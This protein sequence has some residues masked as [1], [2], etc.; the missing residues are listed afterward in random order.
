[1]YLI[2][3]FLGVLYIIDIINRNLYKILPSIK[4]S[5]FF[6]R[7]LDIKEVLSLK[8]YII[9]RI[10][11][12]K[13]LKNLRNINDYDLS[14][15]DADSLREVKS[16]ISN[17]LKQ[18][19]EKLMSAKNISMLD[20]VSN[21]IQ[22]TLNHGILDLYLSQDTSFVDYIG[23][24]FQSFSEDSPLLEISTKAISYTYKYK[25]RFIR[26]INP[27]IN[28]IYDIKEIIKAIQLNCNINQALSLKVA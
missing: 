12:Y 7:K 21:H 20:Q 25:S 16:Y 4:T 27:N 9:T 3:S 11:I 19:V 10:Q 22:C 24:K 5:E 14:K 26:F 28:V 17:D 23:I 2:L 1:M 6:A 15:Y 8:E 13:G 18:Y